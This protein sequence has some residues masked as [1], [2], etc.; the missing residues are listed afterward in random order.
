MDSLPYISEKL[1]E[2]VLTYPDVIQAVE[3]ALKDFSDRENGNVVQPVRSV[4][5]V[6]D[7][8]GLVVTIVHI[9]I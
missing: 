8:N 7:H 4:L 5:R 2:S 6:D 3:K 1:V 9:K